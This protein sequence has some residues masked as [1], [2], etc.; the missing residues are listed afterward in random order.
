[1]TEFKIKATVVCEGAGANAFSCGKEGEA[2]LKARANDTING[3]LFQEDSIPSG[4]QRTSWPSEDG[5]ICE[6]CAELYNK[7]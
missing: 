1:M 7:K 5:L 3:L 2:V 4:W 6:T